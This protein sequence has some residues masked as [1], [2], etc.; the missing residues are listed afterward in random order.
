MGNNNNHE[1]TPSQKFIEK[2]MNSVKG[3]QHFISAIDEIKFKLHENYTL[4]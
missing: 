2:L 3:E 1:G 4:L